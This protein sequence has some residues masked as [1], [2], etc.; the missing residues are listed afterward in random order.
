LI[1][2]A[3]FLEQ[4]AL[5]V[6]GRLPETLLKASFSGQTRREFRHDKKEIL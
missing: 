3:N 2:K 4:K 6:S 1:I 5:A